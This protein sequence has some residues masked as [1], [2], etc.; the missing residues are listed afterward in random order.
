LPVIPFRRGSVH[1]LGGEFDPGFGL[2]ASA[3]GGFQQEPGANPSKGSQSA[4]APPV[5][6]SLLGMS[7]L[8]Q[9]DGFL[10]K[11]RV[12]LDY[13]IQ[14]FDREREA[15]GRLRRKRENEIA[16]PAETGRRAG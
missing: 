5:F 12:W 6:F 7:S 9:L 11:H 1:G 3:A 10:K 2:F 15:S 16:E 13:S 4:F 14:D 8:E